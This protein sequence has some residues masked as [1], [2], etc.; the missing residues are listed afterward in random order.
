MND[1]VVLVK[2]G[3]SSITHKG[4]KETLN[5]SAL[6]WLVNTVKDGRLSER[7]CPHRTRRR[8]V[9]VHGA[10]SYGHQV[11]KEYGLSGKTEPPPISTAN[12]YEGATENSR[13]HSES[14][15]KRI[16]GLSRTRQ[17]VQKL[18][19]I[20]LAKFLEQD[21]PAIT[22][23]PCFGIPNLQ[24]HGGDH[25]AQEALQSVVQSAVKAGLVPIL[26]GDAGLY[27]EDDVGILSGDTIMKIIGTASFITHVVFVTDVDGV[28][29]ADP[30]LDRSAELIRSLYVDIHTATLLPSA[31]LIH[32]AGS[33][34]AH[35][36][37][38]GLK[39]GGIF[40]KK[41]LY[42]CCILFQCARAHIYYCSPDE[43]RRCSCN[44]CNG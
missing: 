4:V 31:K 2:I 9:V 34:H 10:G 37:T 3:G 36:V 22:I 21:I 23:S 14:G 18:N 16:L 41:L 39:V 6:T 24:A 43:T 35:D 44:S 8:Y 25:C 29:T 11:A 12:S 17:S 32:A 42:A 5:R 30:K 19:Q 26:H 40:K 20:V 7:D 1:E 38:G 13:D 27:G 15:D 28:F 33:S